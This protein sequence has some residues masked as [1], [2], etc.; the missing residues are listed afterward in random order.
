[1]MFIKILGKK[2]LVISYQYSPDAD[3]V[4]VIY[5]DD[6]STAPFLKNY[7]TGARFF[8]EQVSFKGGKDE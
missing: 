4:Y 1:M 5:F 3:Q 2:Y 6:T 8:H 7:S